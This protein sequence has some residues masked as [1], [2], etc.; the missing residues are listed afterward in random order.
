MERLA[1]QI[2]KAQMLKNQALYE[3]EMKMRT[4]MLYNFKYSFKATI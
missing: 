2:C 4:K 1:L 3:P